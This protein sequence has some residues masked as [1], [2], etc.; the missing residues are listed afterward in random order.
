MFAPAPQIGVFDGKGGD[1]ASI[2]GAVLGRADILG[3]WFEVLIRV[4]GGCLG[5]R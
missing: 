2:C 5:G 3:D 4:L 1:G